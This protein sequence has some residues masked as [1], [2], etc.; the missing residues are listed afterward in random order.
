MADPQERVKGICLPED[1]RNSRVMGLRKFS[2]RDRNPL[3]ATANL[4]KLV[5][6]LLVMIKVID[7]KPRVPL[8]HL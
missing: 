3:L 4:S 5:M 2:S 6:G 1:I 7:S 8:H